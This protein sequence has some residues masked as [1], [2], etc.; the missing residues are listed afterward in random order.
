M[1]AILQILLQNL[2]SI[3]QAVVT[4]HGE[5]GQK[6]PGAAKKQLVLNTV[7]VAGEVTGQPVD[8]AHEQALGGLVDATVA[9]LKESG[10][11]PTSTAAPVQ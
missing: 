2:P 5:F 10:Y 8:A 3:I 7:K 11:L 4:I 6:I 1:N 9:T